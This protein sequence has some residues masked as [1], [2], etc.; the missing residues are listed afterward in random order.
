M[1]KSTAVVAGAAFVVLNAVT[2]ARAVMPPNFAAAKIFFNRTGLVENMADTAKAKITRMDAKFADGWINVAN[3]VNENGGVS[4]LVSLDISRE[5]L[6]KI[7]GTGNDP[8]DK[9]LLAGY[10]VAGIPLIVCKHGII[11]YRKGSNTRDPVEDMW[12]SE[13]EIKSATVTPCAGK[14]DWAIITL[15]D[16]EGKETRLVLFVDNRAGKLFRLFDAKKD[17]AP[18]N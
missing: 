13:S 9:D 18:Q 10:N 15:V 8:V 5:G 16:R 7:A 2:Q 1:R 3:Y 4:G 14:D 6:W 12:L 17:P 11:A